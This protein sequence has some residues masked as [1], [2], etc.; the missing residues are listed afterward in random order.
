LFERFTEEGRQVVVFAQEEARGL[1]HSY[2]GTE[3]ILLG[4]LREEEQLG[5]KGP[6]HSL[7]IT[8]EDVRE[9]VRRMVGAGE[10]PS[11][12][13]IP[14]TPRAKKVLELA[15]REALA[16]RH[17][18]IGPEH[19]LLGIVREDEGV[20][21]RVLLDLD[22]DPEKVRNEV[23]R[24]LGARPRGRGL[25]SAFSAARVPL[26]TAWLDAFG[27][28]LEKLG[29]EIRA[30]L[31]RDPDVGDLLLVIACARP[32]VAGQALHD[33]GV[34]LDALWGTLERVRQQRS[35]DTDALSTRIEEVRAQKREALEREAFTEAGNLRDKER[36]LVQQRQSGEGLG[37]EVLAEI[38]RRLGLPDP[39]SEPPRAREG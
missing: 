33:I 24:V 10:D 22:A 36:T 11:T 39:G 17:N 29:H 27:G 32:T 20:A 19:V 5:G 6:L 4:V 15:L 14:F 38:R 7:G 9:R 16:L 2:I 23:A 31:G 28:E 30:G 12:G 35:E 18:W 25:P 8:L 21:S 3:H 34:D 26:D 37:A 13:M 1:Y